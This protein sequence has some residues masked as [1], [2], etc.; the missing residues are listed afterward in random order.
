MRLTI[1]HSV[2]TSMQIRKQKTTSRAPPPP[3]LASDASFATC[4]KSNHTSGE[5]WNVAGRRKKTKL[6]R[7]LLWEHRLSLTF[8][9]HSWLRVF[10]LWQA[11]G[12]EGAS[13]GC[14]NINYTFVHLWLT[15][16]RPWLTPEWKR[17]SQSSPMVA[18]SFQPT[19]CTW[20]I[21]PLS[22]KWNFCL[23]EAIMI[24]SGQTAESNED[25]DYS[26]HG[27]SCRADR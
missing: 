17:S 23:N 19:D 5:R 21:K 10:L 8:I 3:A 12:R 16:W 27:L 14:P 15:H 1:Y 13:R 18:F 6:K 25:P 11:R 9:H 24:S 7:I 4:G 20:A 2:L 22:T 26:F